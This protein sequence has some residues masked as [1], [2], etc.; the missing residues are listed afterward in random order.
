MIWQVITK[1]WFILILPLLGVQAPCPHFTNSQRC[2]ELE[3]QSYSEVLM[4]STIIQ[5]NSRDFFEMIVETENEAIVLF[6]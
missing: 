1:L 2:L 4:L 5:V 3:S 6:G